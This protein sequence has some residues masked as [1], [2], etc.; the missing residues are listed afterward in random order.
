MNGSCFPP[1]HT[2][3]R[4]HVPRETSSTNLFRS[5]C[6]V[7]VL[8]RRWA[9]GRIFPEITYTDGLAVLKAAAEL[10]GLPSPL[11]WDTHCFRRGWADDV[12]REGGPGALFYSGGWKG[13][14][15]FGYANARTRGALQAAE[16]C[17]DHSGFDEDCE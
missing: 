14:A 2:S 6:G 17:V 8:S 7:C 9:S 12:L 10:T 15:A 1:Q 16:F 5:V 3:S 11:T 13:V 4:F